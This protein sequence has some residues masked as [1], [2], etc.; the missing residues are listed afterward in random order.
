MKFNCACNT[1][2]IDI[3]KVIFADHLFVRQN[4]PVSANHFREWWR[5]FGGGVEV[6]QLLSSPTSFSLLSSIFGDCFEFVN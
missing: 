5:T 2:A 3:T 6:C 1:K 4:Y